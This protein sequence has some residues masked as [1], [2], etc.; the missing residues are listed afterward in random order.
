MTRNDK[1]ARDLNEVT[2]KDAVLASTTN[3]SIFP[4]LKYEYEEDKH[5]FIDGGEGGEHFNNNN[6]AK[7]LVVEALCQGYALENINVISL[8]TGKIH[9]ESTQDKT[10]LDM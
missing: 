10:K 3:P 9:P 5:R 4:N 7:S 6:P 1:L 2:Y 8:G